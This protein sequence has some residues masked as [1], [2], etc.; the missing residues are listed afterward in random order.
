MV[1]EYLLLHIC[2]LSEKQNE[3]INVKIR[4]KK[5]IGKKKVKNPSVQNCARSSNHKKLPTH[6]K[7]IYS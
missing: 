2:G 7:L 6:I 4:M 5:D 1:L 3:E